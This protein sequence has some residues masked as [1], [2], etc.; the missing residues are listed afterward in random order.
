MAAPHPAY[1][2]PS[3]PAHIGRTWIKNAGAEPLGNT[4]KAITKL[5]ELSLLD[6][7][8]LRLPIGKD[9]VALIRQELQ[10]RLALL[11]KYESWSDG[12]AP[13]E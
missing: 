3:L 2:K 13:G 1:S 11:E 4:K 5:Y 12:I 10:S 6:D 7:P 9:S 8:P